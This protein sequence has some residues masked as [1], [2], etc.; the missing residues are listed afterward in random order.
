MGEGK[1]KERG[2]RVRE[3]ALISRLH[4]ALEVVLGPPF[5]RELQRENVERKRDMI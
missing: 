5:L 4:V 2:R 1:G 3:G